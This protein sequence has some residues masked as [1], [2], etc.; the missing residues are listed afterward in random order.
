MAEPDFDFGFGNGR[1][2]KGHGWRGLVALGFL[3]LAAVVATGSLSKPLASVSG[4]SASAYN[5]I[6]AR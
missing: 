5:L 3:L 1:Y 2:L 4:S 6:F